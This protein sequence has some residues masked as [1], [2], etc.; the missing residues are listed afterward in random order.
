MEG[1]NEI[2]K[3]SLSKWRLEGEKHVPVIHAPEK[4]K[5]GDLVEVQVMVG[6]EIAHPNTFE[7]YISWIKVY[8]QPEGHKFQ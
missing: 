3:Q 2:I 1:I 5:L 4:V 8:Y 6:D 7:H